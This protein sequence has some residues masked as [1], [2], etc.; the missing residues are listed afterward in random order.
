MF[1][2]VKVHTR[3]WREEELSKCN[4]MCHDNNSWEIC[5]WCQYQQCSEYIP[6]QTTITTNTKFGE[7]K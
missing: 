4:C 7:K 6:I 5:N 1:Q 3:I 2:Q